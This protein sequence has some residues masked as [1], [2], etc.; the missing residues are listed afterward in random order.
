MGPMPGTPEYLN[1]V[2]TIKARIIDVADL[3]ESAIQKVL[4]MFIC[5]TSYSRA[6]ICQAEKEAKHER[7]LS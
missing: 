5:D 2:A 3:G 1:Q 4:F 7:G 6:A